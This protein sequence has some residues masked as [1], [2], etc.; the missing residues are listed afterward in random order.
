MEPFFLSCEK[1]NKK[2]L[3]AVSSRNFRIC[4]C[5][6]ES[7]WIIP[8]F[9]YKNNRTVIFLWHDLWHDRLLFFE[10]KR[11]S[12]VLNNCEKFVFS[13]TRS[14]TNGRYL[15]T[16]LFEW[17]VFYGQLARTHGIRNDLKNGE[18]VPRKVR[19][20]PTL[21]WIYLQYEQK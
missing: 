21:I 13:A 14:N 9:L 10:E 5:E 4:N 19:V 7:N 18:K 3:N 8:I 17:R 15:A 12:F 11:F 20:C 16:R 1:T 2:K 6:T